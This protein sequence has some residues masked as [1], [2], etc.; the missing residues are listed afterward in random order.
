LGSETV[1]RESDSLPGSSFLSSLSGFNPSA[2]SIWVLEHVS[3]GFNNQI[4]KVLWSFDKSL[5]LLV[6]PHLSPSLELE[7]ETGLGDISNSNSD[8]PQAVGSW[9]THD[10]SWVIELTFDHD[11][12]PFASVD[13]LVSSA[14]T[15]VLDKS[16]TSIFISLRVE[17][18][19]KSSCAQ[20]S[21]LDKEWRV[22]SRSF[23]LIE[24]PFG[25]LVTTL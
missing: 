1:V 5:E 10:D 19:L 4:G 11:F 7:C 16:L 13:L 2:A 24:L 8:G 14:H 3:T 9:S 20:H 18:L 25:G 15:T 21:L 6:G 22:F 17:G 23:L 12:L